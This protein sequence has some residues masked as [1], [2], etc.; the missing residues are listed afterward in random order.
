MRPYYFKGKCGR[1]PKGIQTMMRM[2][3]IRIWF[4]LA[5]EGAEE[6]INGSYTEGGHRLGFG[7]EGSPDAAPLLGFRHVLER[8]GLQKNSLKRYTTCWK[9]RGSCRG[10]GSQ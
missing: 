8:H 5:D 7:E 3:L 2:H 6:Q 4:N 1:P 10:E 9:N